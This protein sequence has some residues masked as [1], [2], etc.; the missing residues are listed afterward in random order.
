MFFII[1]KILAFLIKPSFWILTLL[2]TSIIIKNKRTLLLTLTLFFYVFFTN[3]YLYNKLVKNWETKQISINEIEENYDLG[4]VLG[5]FSDYDYNTNRHNFKKEADRLIYTIQLYNRGVIKK[6]FISGGNGKLSSNKFKESET[7]KSFLINNNIPKKDI[8]I[9]SES[10]NTRE[11]AL[12]TAKLIRRNSKNLLITSAIHMK[13]SMLCFEK[14]GINVV[15]FPVDNTMTYSSKNIEHI[16][17]PKARVLEYWEEF[18]HEIIGYQIYKI[19][20]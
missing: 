5:G 19:T 12:F 6:I 16:I 10:K 2:L 8:L 11:N 7:I 3:E 20:F 14:A 9:E 15:A 18:I 13:R 4:I 17:L 1:S